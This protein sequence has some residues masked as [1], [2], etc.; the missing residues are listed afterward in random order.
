MNREQK[1]KALVDNDFRAVDRGDF[2]LVDILDILENG[3]VG[4]NNFTD[5]QLDELVKLY[6]I[7]N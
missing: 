5:D 1:I 4:Y 6:E 7:E 2:E 3:F